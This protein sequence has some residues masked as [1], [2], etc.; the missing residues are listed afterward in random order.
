MQTYYVFQN[1]DDVFARTAREWLACNRPTPVWSGQAC[2]R[3]DA[4]RQ[5]LE[6]ILVAA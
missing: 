1:G 6:T 5:Y 2:G 3:S 4:I